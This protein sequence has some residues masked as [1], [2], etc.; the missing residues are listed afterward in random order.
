MSTTIQLDSIVFSDSDVEGWAF[1]SLTDWWGSTAN[2]VEARER[3]QAHGSFQRA[4]SLR[5]SRAISFVAR[6]RGADHLEVERAF[7]ALSATGAETPVV[8]RVTTEDGSWWRWVSVEAVTPESTRN[9]WFGQATV[10]VLAEDGRRYADASWLSTAPPTEGAGLEWPAVWPAVWPGGGVDG[11]VTLAN[12]GRAPSAPSFQ[13]KGGFDT[14]TVTCMETGAR[15]G[16]DRYVPPG[17]TVLIDTATRR[18][19]IDDQSDVSRWLRFREWETVPPGSSRAYQFD[20]T[21]A[22]GSPTLEGRV[23]PAWW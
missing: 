10:D 7:D 18:A 13:L 12:T 1:L 20:V 15:I 2:K 19:V 3:P 22:S 6:Y 9:R 4:R 17:S 8:M 5:S 21:G 16:F 23:F 14:A 11:R